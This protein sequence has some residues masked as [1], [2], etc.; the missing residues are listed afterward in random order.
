MDLSR[1]FDTSGRQDATPGALIRVVVADEHAIIRDAVRMLCS[2]Q[3]DLCVVGEAVDGQ[4]ALDLAE[5]LQPDVLILD[6]TMPVL[7]GVQVAALLRQRGS[8]V[9]VLALTRHKEDV[10]LRELLRA[11]ASGY[12]L[13]HSSAADLLTGIRT[14]ASGRQYLDPALASGLT[15]ADLTR[16]SASA[17]PTL[18]PRETEVLQLTVWGH[19]NTEIASR[20]KISVKTVETHKAHG[21]EKLGLRSRIELTRF[22]LVSGWFQEP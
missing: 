21:L 11:G 6:V 17:A 7:N 4:A 9:R 22:A 16:R 10:Y 12:A 19:R 2:A 1:S 18:S 15:R 13:T 5:T 3:S 8:D 14:V 20:L